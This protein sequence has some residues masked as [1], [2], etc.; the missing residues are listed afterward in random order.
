MKSIFSML[1]LAACFVARAQSPDPY[2][3]KWYGEMGIGAASYNAFAVSL[4]GHTV[5]PDRWKLGLSYHYAEL[6][7]KNLPS[8]YRP[9]NFIFVSAGNPNVAMRMF[10]VT[11]GRYFPVRR[12]LWFTA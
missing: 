2:A 6:D 10:S 1:L 7:P 12:K 4:G 5:L 11:A 8:D 3:K 9:D